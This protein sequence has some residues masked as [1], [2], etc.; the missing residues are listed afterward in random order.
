MFG[1]TPGI[2]GYGLNITIPDIALTPNLT[3]P[4]TNSSILRRVPP[5]DKW[6]QISGRVQYVVFDVLGWKYRDQDPWTVA[7]YVWY[8]YLSSL[9][10]HPSDQVW[11]DIKYDKS[12]CPIVCDGPAL[13][14]LEPYCWDSWKD[15]ARLYSIRLSQHPG[16][17]TTQSEDVWR[18]AT[19]CASITREHTPGPGADIVASTFRSKW[20]GNVGIPV[21]IRTTVDGTPTK[22]VVVTP[23]PT[24]LPVVGTAR[25][26][27]GGGGG[28]GG[29]NGGHEDGGHGGTRS[30]TEVWITTTLIRQDSLGRP[31]STITAV[32]RAT[33]TTMTLYDSSGRPTATITTYL[34]LAP[35]IRT[36]DELRDGRYDPG[37]TT[38]ITTGMVPLTPGGMMVVTDSRGIPVATLRGYRSHDGRP[39][40]T[41]KPDSDSSD[42]TGAFGGSDGDWSGVGSGETG[43]GAE[44]VHPLSWGDYVVASFAPVL[45]AL[46]LAIL[47]Q[48]QSS[49]IKQLLPVHVLS[50][51]DGQGVSAGKSLCL[52]TGG[53]QGLV[54]SIQLLIKE[55]D[56]LLFLADLH[57]LASS[58]V[59]SFSSEAMGVKLYGQCTPQ[60]FTGCRLGIAV[61]RVPG[62]MVEGFLVLAVVT[63]LVINVLLRRSAWKTAAEIHSRHGGR[64]S[65]ATSLLTNSP[66]EARKYFEKIASGTPH[67]AVSNK[68]LKKHFAGCLFSI[69][70]SSSLPSTTMQPEKQHPQLSGGIPNTNFYYLAVTPSP[71][72][73]A[74]MFEEEN[75]VSG[76]RW[77]E[78]LV[79]I[80]TTRYQ[81]TINQVG[82]LL[83]VI[84]FLIMLFYYELTNTTSAFEHF[85]NSQGLGVRAVFTGL[86]VI[87]SLFWDN[88]FSSRCFLLV[89]LLQAT[90]RVS[91]M[92][93]RKDH[94]VNFTAAIR[95]SSPHPPPL[96]L[97]TDVG[98]AC[99]HPPSFP[100]SQSPLSR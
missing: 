46:P 73:L 19:V 81:D 66:L 63:N 84:G 39:A 94:T 18:D 30:V 71:P 15:K 69:R 29:A 28:D 55:R 23:A 98:V 83:A 38:T 2:P 93:Q 10:G 82:F 31:V 68:E 17:T 53:I 12:A 97:A 8:F 89:S 33:H 74:S 86:G 34:L 95:R 9:T 65:T 36:V 1:V 13:V 24:A 16:A 99:S 92:S 76:R 100:S 96:V 80:F 58:L 51:S 67:G 4:S 44:A 22:V 54:N 59:V 47:I 60:D 14:F 32:L 20:T 41:V 52:T 43:G 90:D 35:G 25:P 45:M 50:R 26:S 75:D 6:G 85:M 91:Q 11:L 7:S 77:Q 42:R 57:V 72:N 3:T 40:V 5:R 78:R 79:G 87:V 61:F 62:R 64:V 27:I 49:T 70:S 37:L 88:Y 48:I 21:T 56:P